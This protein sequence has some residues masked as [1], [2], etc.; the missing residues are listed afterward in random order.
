[1][2]ISTPDG[3]TLKAWYLPNKT[4][5]TTLVYFHGNGG[6]LTGLADQFQAFKKLEV[7]AL[8]I[9]YR[10]FG[11]SQGDP[12]EEGLYL[13]GLA[14]YDMAKEEPRPLMRSTA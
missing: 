10:G 3:L 1:M 7:E 2:D 14:A 11:D 8:A 13:D 12:S 9:D 4:S 5:D 6:N